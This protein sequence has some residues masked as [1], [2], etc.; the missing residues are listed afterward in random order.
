MFCGYDEALKRATTFAE[1][2][3]I[4]YSLVSFYMP[5]FSDL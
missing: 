1:S 3:V 5:Y 2:G 4:R